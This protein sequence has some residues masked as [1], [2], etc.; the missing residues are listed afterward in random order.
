MRHLLV[1]TLF[2][3]VLAA[4]LDATAQRP[5][6]NRSQDLF[7]AQYDLR[8]DPDDVHSIAALGSMLSSG[9][10]GLTGINVLAVQGTIG[11]QRGTQI[12][13][14]SLFNRVFGASNWVDALNGNRSAA[15]RTVR[16]AVV[17][18]LNSGGRVWVQEAGQSDF[19]AD[20][21]RQVITFRNRVTRGITRSRVVVVQHQASFNEGNTAPADLRF[22]MNNADYRPIDDGNARFGVGTN[23]GPDTGQFLSNNT[24]FI[25]RATSTANTKVSSRRIWR[26]A[27]RLLQ[28]VD[29]FPD[30]SSISRGGVDY[31]DCAEALW[32]F[33]LASSVQ[34]NADFWSR[35]VTSVD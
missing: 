20:W 14:P 11:A 29:Q 16:R 7:L 15:L 23:R 35:F 1:L 18:T 6:F 26:L 4:A 32:I 30:F 31:S 2:V 17:A 34:T 25:T 9:E 24:E 33:S 28:P 10:R 19:T 12:E 13:V 8:P 5:R 21:L 22:V 27:D 3:G